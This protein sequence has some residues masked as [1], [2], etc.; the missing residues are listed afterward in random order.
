MED[1]TFPQLLLARSS[2]RCT[3]VRH[4]EAPISGCTGVT[5]V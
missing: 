4:A 5:D 2:M 3:A 1:S